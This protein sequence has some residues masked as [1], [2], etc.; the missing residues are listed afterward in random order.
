MGND[1]KT[2]SFFCELLVTF[3]ILA[4]LKEALLGIRLCTV[5]LCF[6]ALSGAEEKR[7]KKPKSVM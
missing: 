5:C 6:E 3:V 7:L 2:T 1:F 4:L